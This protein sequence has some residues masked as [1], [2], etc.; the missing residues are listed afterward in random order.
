MNNDVKKIKQMGKPFFYK[1]LII[2]SVLIAIFPF[3]W[4][5]GIP[6]GNDA[7]FH[8]SRVASLAEGLKNGV[9]FPG[10]YADYFEGM[11]YGNGLF[12]PDLFLYIPAVLM[13]MGVSNIGAYKIFLILLTFLVPLS[14]YYS[15]KHVWKSD[16]GAAISALL[17][18]FCSF[19]RT[20]LYL[21]SSIG[22]VLAFV[23]LPLIVAGLWQI[24]I[25]DYNK[26]RLLT[27]SF[28]G[29]ILSHV[30]SAVMM[31]FIS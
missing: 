31:V 27:L 16:F 12:Y 10:V 6:F 1:I 9:L 19:F 2:F 29:L 11:G 8:L 15:V 18:L 17:Y 28:S 13:V 26:W 21:R 30:L 25:G 24:I 22:E 14:M 20:D 5:K 3:L 7:S 23:F 4:I